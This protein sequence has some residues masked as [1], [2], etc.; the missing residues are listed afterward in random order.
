MIYVFDSG[1]WIVL[2][3]H[4]YPKRFPT[5]WERVAQLI[6]DKRIISVREVYHEV[7]ERGDLLSEWAKKNQ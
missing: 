2:L 5:L 3:E 4:F 1:P 6:H 7:E